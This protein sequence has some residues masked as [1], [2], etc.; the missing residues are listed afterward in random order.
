MCGP[1]PRGQRDQLSIAGAAVLL[2]ADVVAPGRGVARSSTST[3]RDVGH[4]AGRR[5]AVP[6]L[7]ARLEEDAVAGADHLDRPAAPLAEADALE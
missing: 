7:L 3:H 6:V 4:E 5:R 2:V 1:S